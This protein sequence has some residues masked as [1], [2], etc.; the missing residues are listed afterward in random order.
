[1][2]EVEEGAELRID[3]SKIGQV[4]GRCPNVMPVA[5]QN[6]DTGEVILVA[7]TNEQ[8]FR[9]ALRDRAAGALEH[10]AQR[11]VGEGQDLRRDLR[12]GRGAREL[13]AELAALPGAPPPRRHLPHEE[14]RR[15]AAQLLLPADRSGHAPARQ[16]RPLRR[17]RARNRSDR[18]SVI[19]RGFDTGH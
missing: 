4:A 13:R 19:G 1:M 3:F 9:R 17:A 12:P 10:V 7:Y 6:A 15:P 11:A 2:N 14:P 8:A 18:Q 5:V 16:P